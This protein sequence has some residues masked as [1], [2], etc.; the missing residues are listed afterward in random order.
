[1]FMLLL[2]GMLPS[3]AASLGYETF[4]DEVQLGFLLPGPLKLELLVVAV[5]L[6]SSKGDGEAE[7]EA[8]LRFLPPLGCSLRSRLLVWKPG[9]PHPPNPRSLHLLTSLGRHR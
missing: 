3:P 6:L 1:M 9:P 7:S 2:P 8:L 5:E 4:T